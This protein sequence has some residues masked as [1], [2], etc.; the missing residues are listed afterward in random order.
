[1]LYLFYSFLSSQ[2]KKY[3]KGSIIAVSG[4]VKES[5]Y[6][7]SFNEPIIEIL[8]NINSPV[9]SQSIG[10]LLPVYSLT[11]GLTSDRFRSFVDKI[12]FLIEFIR[13]P[14]SRKRL[15][16]LSQPNSVSGKV[17]RKG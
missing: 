1:M 6:G 2:S 9:R 12:L 10:R 11:E 15:S 17:E 13:E 4:L 14:I 16:L 8:S 5:K 7:K 3:P